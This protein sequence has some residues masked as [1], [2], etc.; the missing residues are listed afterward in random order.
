MA[1]LY[2]I[3]FNAIHFQEKSQSKPEFFLKL[4]R[5]R[6]YFLCMPKPACIEDQKPF[7]KYFSI[8]S[9]FNCTQLKEVA[10]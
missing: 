7:I 5:L 2:R 3:A 10:V 6:T 8:L 9:V 4:R 1:R